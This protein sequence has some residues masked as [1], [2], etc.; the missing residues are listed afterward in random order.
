MKKHTDKKE[1]E[2]RIERREALV[3]TGKYAAFTAVA[4]MMVLSPQKAF[5]STG[6][7]KTTPS[8]LPNRR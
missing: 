7:Q 3:K 8:R 6:T 5:A 2:K 4:M 1:S